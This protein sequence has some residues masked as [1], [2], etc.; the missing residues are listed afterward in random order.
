VAIQH[1]TVEGA[2]DDGLRLKVE[3]GREALDGVEFS[4]FEAEFECG[5]GGLLVGV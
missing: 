3:F 2:I 4:L 1:Q 5:H